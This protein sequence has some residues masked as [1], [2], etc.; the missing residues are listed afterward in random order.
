MNIFFHLDDIES[1]LGNVVFLPTVFL[2][3]LLIGSH[4]VL[5]VSVFCC[6]YGY[7]FEH[8]RMYGIRSYKYE[9]MDYLD[10]F[11]DDFVVLHVCL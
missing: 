5:W 1:K 3:T 11:D 8:H 6:C 10:Y 2:G 4:A 7:V 9:R